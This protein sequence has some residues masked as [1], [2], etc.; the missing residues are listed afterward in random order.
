MSKSGYLNTRVEPALK[1]EVGAI[2]NKLGLTFTEAVSIYFQQI[3]LQKGIPFAI[4]LP[5]AETIEA[6]DE[7]KS[8]EYREKTKKFK[9]VN[10][11][12]ADLNS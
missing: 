8:P 2:L 10:D 7:I 11:L 6:I 5:N 3:A 4:K 9:T 12:M 1:E